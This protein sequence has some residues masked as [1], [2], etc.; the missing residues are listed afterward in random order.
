V[1]DAI[2]RI[3][4]A[5]L[6]LQAQETLEAAHFLTRA[7]DLWE[8]WV[9]KA[10]PENGVHFGTAY[11]Q[12]N[13]AGQALDVLQA[14]GAAVPSLARCS[15]EEVLG[16]FP[17]VPDGPINRARDAE[18]IRQ[19]GQAMPRLRDLERE[20]AAFIDR[21]SAAPLSAL[22]RTQASGRPPAPA[23]PDGVGRQPQESRSVWPTAPTPEIDKESQAIA[24]LFKYPSWTIAQ[25]AIRLGVDRT[26]LYD[27]PAFRQ[28]AEK[29]GRLK[30]RGPKAKAGS[31]R[32]GH[33]TSDGQVE[34]YVDEEAE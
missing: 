28:A 14:H 29:A 20:L 32:R 31:P 30:P 19:V 17:T 18:F 15:A 6:R 21:L 26:T 4:D 12:Q 13:M 2:A 7:I 3:P 11:Y 16:W 24:L 33:R 22:T 34:A 8:I 5:V 23:A 10:T 1:P 9:L 27:W 25:I